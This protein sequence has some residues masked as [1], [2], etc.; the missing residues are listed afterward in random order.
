MNTTK[1]DC[2]ICNK[3]IN[4]YGNNPSPLLSQGRCCDD[5]DKKFVMTLRFSRFLIKNTRE[6]KVLHQKFIN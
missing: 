2:V 1:I 4:G 3:E 6:K 5:C